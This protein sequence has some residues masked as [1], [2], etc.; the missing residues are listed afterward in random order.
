[1]T[2]SASWALNL[3]WAAISRPP[4]NRSVRLQWWS[5]SDRV[6]RDQFGADPRIVGRLIRLNGIGHTVIGV[7]GPGVEFP[8]GAGLWI[9]L[10]V[11]KN[12]VER[13]G[14]TFLQAIARVKPGYS[15]ERISGPKVKA[16]FKRL[17]VEH[18]EA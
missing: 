2:F 5:L 6:W 17:A 18:P 11:D 1:M 4:M 16:L 7:M 3:C 10:G 8:R 9:P 14:A 12:I 13:R 15:R